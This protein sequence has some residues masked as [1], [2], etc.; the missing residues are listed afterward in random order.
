MDIGHTDNEGK[1][2]GP[3]W[4][5]S[6]PRLDTNNTKDEH[7]QKDDKIPPFRNCPSPRAQ[8]NEAPGN[9]GRRVP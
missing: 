8:V 1:H 9:K 7:G 6:G 5:L 3:D 2:E 4:H